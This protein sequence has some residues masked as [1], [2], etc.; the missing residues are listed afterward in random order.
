[1]ARAGAVAE[2]IGG[3]TKEGASLGDVEIAQGVLFPENNRAGPFLMLQEPIDLGLAHSAGR[4]LGVI[5]WF[6]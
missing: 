3:V 5:F 6:F 1:M 2:A 4:A